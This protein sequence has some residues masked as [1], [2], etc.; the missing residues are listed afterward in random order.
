LFSSNPE[1]SSKAFKDSPQMA[2][3]CLNLLVARLVE[4]EE[5]SP[6]QAEAYVAKPT[7]GA[8]N[9]PFKITWAEFAAKLAIKRK[10]SAEESSPVSS[11]TD[12]GK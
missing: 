3:E 9:R 10:R 12:K 2:F 5:L 6:Q 8:V 11:K 4:R 1:L 7:R